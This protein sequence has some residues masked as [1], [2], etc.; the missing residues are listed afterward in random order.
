MSKIALGLGDTFGE[1]YRQWNHFSPHL[2]FFF[3]NH[4]LADAQN[5]QSKIHCCG[6]LLNARVTQYMQDKELR[7]H[8]IG[9]LLEVARQKSFKLYNCVFLSVKTWCSHFTIVNTRDP[10]VKCSASHGGIVFGIVWELERGSGW[11]QLL[12]VWV[13]LE[14]PS[15]RKRRGLLSALT[16]QTA[17]GNASHSSSWQ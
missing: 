4:L 17:P 10:D 12:G 11:L 15:W 3:L 6:Q 8:W 7:R 14:H 13:D 16:S 9:G 5:L 2:W 1:L